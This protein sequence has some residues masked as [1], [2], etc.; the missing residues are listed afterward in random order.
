MCARGRCPAW[1]LHLV[2]APAAVGQSGRASAGLD[3]PCLADWWQQA[4]QHPAVPG[5]FG[6]WYVGQQTTSSRS[7]RKKPWGAQE[8]IREWWQPSEPA[9]AWEQAV[10]ECVGIRYTCEDKIERAHR[11]TDTHTHLQTVHLHQQLC[12][13]ALPHTRTSTTVATR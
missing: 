6:I 1:L 4:P 3:P 11:D 2:A 8:D 12:Q 9:A 10:C 13:D 7:A 5:V